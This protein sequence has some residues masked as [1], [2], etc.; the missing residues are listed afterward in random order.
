MANPNTVPGQVRGAQAPS[1][2]LYGPMASGK[3]RNGH[4]IA[5]KLGLQHVRD[6]DDVQLSGDRLQRH[7]YL[8]LANSH[9]YAKRA[10]D[11]LGT[12]LI[13]IRQGLALVAARRQGVP[14]A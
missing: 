11:L 2:V 7:G 10:A 14:N 4:A 6:L 1:R 13:N 5:A 3:T 8:Y 12:N 9:D